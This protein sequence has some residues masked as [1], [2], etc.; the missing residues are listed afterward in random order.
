[1]SPPTRIAAVTGGN[2]GIGL[3]I[4]RQLALQYPQSKFNNGPF[5]IY[6]GARDKSRGEQAVEELQADKQLKTAKAL[7][8]DGGLTDIKYASLDI[9]DKKSIDDF[10]AFLKKEHGQ[11]DMLI[12]NAGVAIDGFDSDVVE[13]TLAINYYGTLE[14]CETILPLIRKGGRLVNVSSMA[15]KLHKYSQEL[16]DRFKNG[17]SVQDYTKLMEEFKQGVRDGHWTKLGWPTTAYSVSKSGV[18]GITRALAMQEQSK[19]SEVLVNSCCPGYV[20]TDMT[21]HRG[22]LTP[23]Q[24]ARTPVLLALG[25]LQGQSGLFWEHE[26]VSSW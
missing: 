3:A 25:D 12:N 1:M 8:Q 10:A 11:I 21:K 4:V 24:G 9:A 20:N 16:Q 19:G 17:K 6:L 18:T 2:K 5:L 13:K 7:V 15:C 22:Q 23:D 14:A 26:Q